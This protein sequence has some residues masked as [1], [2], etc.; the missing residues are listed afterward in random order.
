MRREGWDT[1]TPSCGIAVYISKDH[2][3]VNATKLVTAG[4]LERFTFDATTLFTKAPPGSE[5]VVPN[6]NFNQI[7]FMTSQMS[8][9]WFPDTDVSWTLKVP[10]EN[11]ALVSVS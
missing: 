8:T 1:L 3:S 11:E 10:D 4:T 6:I 9:H 7:R 2:G 5:I